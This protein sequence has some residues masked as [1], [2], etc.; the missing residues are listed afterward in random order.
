[1]A[2][3][4]SASGYLDSQTTNNTALL[5][6][7][8][9]PQPTN[10]LTVRT[11][12]SQVFDP[13][14]GTLEQE[15]EI[16]NTRSQDIPGFR[17]SVGGL[18]GQLLEAVG[19]NNSLPYVAYPGVVH[20]GQAVD[21]WLHFF[22]LD[23]NPVTNL[24]YSAVAFTASVPSLPTIGS[25]TPGSIVVL[26]NGGTLVEFPSVAGA[27]YVVVYA[28]NA[29]FTDA[30]VSLPVV[31]AHADRTQWVDFGPPLTISPPTHQPNRFYKVYPK[32]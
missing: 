26:P 3:S 30:A 10:Q 32:P 1:M 20:P 8:V 15:V 9:S 11:V 27:S 12:S 25:L 23:R 28:S 22:V 14:T 2:G 24:V 17:L 21:L 5:E 16:L 31:V 7:K 29:A 4:V 19:T 13:Q 18:S 6:L